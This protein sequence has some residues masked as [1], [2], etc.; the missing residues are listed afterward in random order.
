MFCVIWREL[1]CE[2]YMN[3][4]DFSWMLGA[5]LDHSMLF[6]IIINQHAF[7]FFLLS[8]L[9]F[10]FHTQIE[11]LVEKNR[12][13]FLHRKTRQGL[14]FL[15]QSKSLS[16]VHT[17]RWKFHRNYCFVL[18]NK[19]KEMPQ[20]DQIFTISQHLWKKC[21]KIAGGWISSWSPDISYNRNDSVISFKIFPKL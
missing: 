15:I 8:V 2:Q 19:W 12:T 9:L 6:K 17:E 1:W 21:Q 10:E 16:Q 5:H 18:V 7:Y 3:W 11:T 13:H 20:K 4:S 14:L